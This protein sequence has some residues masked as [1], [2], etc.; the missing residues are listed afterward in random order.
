MEMLAF[1]EANN[2]LSYSDEFE[3]EAKDKAKVEDKSFV[4]VEEKSEPNPDIGDLVNQHRKDNLV[5]AV[6]NL[7]RS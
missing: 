3:S 2:R 1:Q 5:D 7:F 6:R 4:L